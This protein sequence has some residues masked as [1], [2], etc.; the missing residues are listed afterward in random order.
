VT[1][2][3]NW[4]IETNSEDY[5]GQQKK[6]AQVADRRP[7]IRKASD[8]VG[9]GI[10][11][12]AVRLT[13]LNDVVAT[14]NGYFSAGLGADNSPDPTAD[15]LVGWVTTDSEFGGGQFFMR[16]SDG[17][18]F[19][20]TFLRAPWSPSSI[21][22]GTWATIGGGGSTFTR[23][24]STPVATS[25]AAG[26]YATI[27]VSLALSYRLLSMTVDK[28]C[29][30]R[31]FATAAGAAADIGRPVSTDPPDGRGVMLDYV[32]TAP[33]TYL[34][35]PLVDGASMETVPSTSITAV[36]DNTA[37]STQT[38]TVS[39]NYLPTE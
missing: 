2:A 22:W 11:A 21:I 39:F 23:T 10:G 7:V 27:T 15:A 31:L 29:R 26:S 13:D 1:H 38:I 3:A 9:P 18:V 24:T 12:S 17:V 5:F 16:L 20:R 6:K 37:V 33:G 4:R 25:I 35:S 14:Y 8:L 28:A 34:L 36:V 19:T 32:A 30:V